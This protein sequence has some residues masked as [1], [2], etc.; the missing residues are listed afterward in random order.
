MNRLLIPALGLVAALAFSV[1]TFQ[2]TPAG[3]TTTSTATATTAAPKK[4][5]ATMHTKTCKPS[6]LH[7]CPV[8]KKK[9][10]T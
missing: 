8:V 3:A 2:V 7:K 1:P 10:K 4:K 9:K 6:K 5:V